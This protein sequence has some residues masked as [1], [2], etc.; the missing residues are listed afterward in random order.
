MKAFV[1]TV[2][3]LVVGQGFCDSTDISTLG[4][5]GVFLC[6]MGKFAIKKALQNEAEKCIKPALAISY[7]DK[8]H[9]K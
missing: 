9:S 6:N 2:Y 5:E 3:Y 8:A 7:F 1:F 4:V